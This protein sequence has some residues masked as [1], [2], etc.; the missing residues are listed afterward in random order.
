MGNSRETVRQSVEGCRAGENCRG[1]RGSSEGRQRDRELA[2]RHRETEDR[3]RL[4]ETETRHWTK[5]R[6]AGPPGVAGLEGQH[7]R[8]VCLGTVPC[9]LGLPWG[10]SAGS[11]PLPYRPHSAPSLGHPPGALQA[12]N[13]NLLPLN[14]RLPCVRVKS[15]PLTIRGNNHHAPCDGTDSC[16]RVPDH[17]LISGSTVVFSK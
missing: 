7:G 4:R 6:A 9:T 17:G 2:D 16:Y 14:P 11:A 12:K 1:A 3:G 5:A 8:L 13:T 15:S 10:P